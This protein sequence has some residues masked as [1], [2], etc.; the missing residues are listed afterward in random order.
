MRIL[1]KF[2]K[3]LELLKLR[4]IPSNPFRVDG[5]KIDNEFSFFY[6]RIVYLHYISNARVKKFH[7]SLMMDLAQIWIFLVR[8]VCPRSGA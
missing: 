8:L 2:S 7:G 6:F 4:A 3:I 1:I 5:L